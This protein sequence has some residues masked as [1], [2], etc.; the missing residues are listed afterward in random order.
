MRTQ[1]SQPRNDQVRWIG[2]PIGLFQHRFPL[3]YRQRESC[4]EPCQ[5]RTRIEAALLGMGLR[6]RD[7]LLVNP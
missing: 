7:I 5:D 4:K 1:I 6:E 2:S 3:G